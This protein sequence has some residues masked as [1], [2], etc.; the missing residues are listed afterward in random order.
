MKK[1]RTVSPELFVQLY[2]ESAAAG[3]TMSQFA[4]RLGWSY[5]K[6]HSRVRYY[7]KR[8][9]KAPP[10]VRKQREDIKPQLDIGRLNQITAAESR[11]LTGECL[12][13]E[14]R[15][16]LSDLPHSPNGWASIH[17]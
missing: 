1:T 5:G 15:V 16:T 3:H 4:E 14:P 8:G 13:R 17:S 10:L 7:K 12:P 11:R 2:C 9:W 6:A